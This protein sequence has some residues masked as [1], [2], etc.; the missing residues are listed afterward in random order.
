MQAQGA[1]RK[2][3]GTLSGHAARLVYRLSAS[4]RLTVAHCTD[5]IS[6][7]AAATV[8][9]TPMGVSVSV[10]ARFIAPGKASGNFLPLLGGGWEGVLGI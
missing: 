5:N 2:A 3:Q 6:S 1:R 4:V 10:G 7:C 9:R 8:K